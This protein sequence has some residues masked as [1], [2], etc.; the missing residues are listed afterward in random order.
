MVD[1]RPE[2]TGSLPDSSR[3]KREPP[4]IDLEATEVSSETQERCRAH[5]P[6]RRP[7]LRP[8]PRRRPPKLPSGSPVACAAVP[9]CLALDR[10]AGLRRGC[11]GAGDRRRLDAG[12]ARDSARVRAA[13]PAAQCRHRRSHRPCRRT[14]AKGRQ[15]RARSRRCRAH[16]GA[17]KNR[18]GVA[19][20]TRGNAGARREA[21]VRHQRGEIRAARRRHRVAPISPGSMSASRRSRAR[22]GRRAPRSRSK[23][24]SLPMPRPTPN[25]PTT[26]RCAAW[27]RRRC[28][29][30]WS[31]SA[32]PIRRRSPRP[33]R[34][35]PIRMS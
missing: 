2:D 10:R 7:S 17:G 26:C 19:R 9:A 29:M 18:R 13:C 32:I 31:V 8:S 23:A 11:R 12:L 30:C 21:R 20:R 3:P 25:L 4:T 5:R 15:A 24:A 6:K 34:W 22:C 14:G 1:D 28:S 27:W 16:R 35:R 33:R